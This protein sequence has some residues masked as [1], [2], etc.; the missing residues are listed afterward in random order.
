MQWVFHQRGQLWTSGLRHHRPGDTARPESY[1]VSDV[2]TVS[3][4]ILELV[5][6]VWQ[7]YQ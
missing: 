7:P 3:L 5:A 1:R 4:D 2:L 6:G